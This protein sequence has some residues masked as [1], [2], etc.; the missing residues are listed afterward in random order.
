MGIFVRKMGY[1]HYL[2]N[3][4]KKQNYESI[5]IVKTHRKKNHHIDV[6]QE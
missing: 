5:V 6:F 3:I 1:L 2:C 4:T